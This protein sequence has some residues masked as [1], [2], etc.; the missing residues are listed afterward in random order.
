M[1]GNNN[2][3]YFGSSA[4]F[5]PFAEKSVGYEKRY[6]CLYC[7]EITK[8]KNALLTH[9]PNRIN[10]FDKKILKHNRIKHSYVGYINLLDEHKHKLIEFKVYQDKILSNLNSSL[11][12]ESVKDEDVFSDDD[13][14][15][16]S[17]E[18]LSDELGKAI[19]FY[20]AKKH[21]LKE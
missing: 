3:M 2:N 8:D 15:S 9:D 21:I 14:I 16:N 5:K 4:F 6:E 1:F 18:F 13:V 20:K 19:E 10:R 17:Q 12:I 7:G 11:L